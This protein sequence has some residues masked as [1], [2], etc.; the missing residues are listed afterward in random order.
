MAERRNKKLMDNTIK[1][2]ITGL[3]RLW[4]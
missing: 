2:K 1:M 3:E 4:E